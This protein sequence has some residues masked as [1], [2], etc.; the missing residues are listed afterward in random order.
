MREI[1]KY[2]YAVGILQARQKNWSIKKVFFY[3]EHYMYFYTHLVVYRVVHADWK[4]QINCES[5]LSQ[6]QE[7]LRHIGELKT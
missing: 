7:Y 1:D 4:L 5:A 3:R 6:K 2:L